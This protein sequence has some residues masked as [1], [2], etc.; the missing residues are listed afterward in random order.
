MSPR[1]TCWRITVGL[2]FSATKKTTKNST[3]I[4]A[5]I[6]QIHRG[7]LS[8]EKTTK[9]QKQKSNRKQQHVEIPLIQP[10]NGIQA[11]AWY[12]C[13]GTTRAVSYNEIKV[14]HIVIISVKW[15]RESEREREEKNP[16]CWTQWHRVPTQ[17]NIHR[18]LASCSSSLSADDDDIPISS[19]E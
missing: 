12:N 3:I 17:H 9:R 14:A 15:E 18:R 16:R 5:V 13:V 6:H 1:S 19:E 8:D 11:V 10:H 2:Y 7:N 4:T